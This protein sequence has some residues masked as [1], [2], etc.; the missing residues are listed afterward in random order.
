MKDEQAATWAD[1][2]LLAKNSL[3]NL[4]GL[5]LPL[6]VAIVT[7]PLLLKGLGTERFGVLTLVWSGIGY[8]SLFD[9]G[10]SQALTKLVAEKL[11][12]GRGEEIPGLV[13][14]GLTVMVGMGVLGSLAVAALAPW[15]VQNLLKIG[16]ELHTEASASFFILSVTIPV[17]VATAGLCGVLEA[18]QRFDL[19]NLVRVPLGLFNYL[20]PLVVVLFSRNLVWVVGALALGR[21]VF[22]ACYG[23]LC[24]REVPSL[25]RLCYD[26]RSVGPLLSYGGWTTVTNLIAPLMIY[27]D[28]FLIGAVVSVAAVA[29]Y[30]TPF[31]VIFRLTVVPVAIVGALFPAFAAGLARDRQRVVALFERGIHYIFLILFPLTLIIV[32]L[33]GEGLELWLGSEFAAN[34]RAVLRWL[35]VGVFI[36][37]FARVPFNLILAQGRPDMTTKLFLAELPLYLIGLWFLARWY[38]IEGVA[39]AWTLRIACDTV[40]FFGITARL[41][42]EV[43]ESLLRWL[44]LLAIAM[45]VLLFCCMASDFVWRGILLFITLVVFAP[46]AWL[47]LL[48]YPERRLLSERLKMLALS[49]R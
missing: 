44:W 43:G 28:R 10:L 18:H 37:G 21:L 31:E 19:I 9:M 17:V 35:M 15:L 39:I 12:L 13:W 29:Y 20:S 36:N 48:D 34:S 16:A 49:W 4:A 3:W 24:L 32:T 7:V 25:R 6:L 26:R 45:L 8:F 38:G 30:T 11:G 22:A 47:Y 46:V 27:M 42:P 1:G 2:H 41:L 14:T 5:V 40:I 23:W 33:A